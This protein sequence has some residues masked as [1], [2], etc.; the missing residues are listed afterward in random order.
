MI[1]EDKN[2][3]AKVICDS[4]AEGSI[5]RM[6]TFE[7]QFPRFILAEL[8]THGMLKKCTQSSRAVPIKALLDLYKDEFYI[9]VRFGKNQAGMSSREYLSEVE[10]MVAG[11]YWIQ[12]EASIRELVEVLS[13]KEG[14]NVHKQWA[15]R[16]YEPFMYIKLVITATEWDNFFWLRDDEDAAQP[17]MVDLARK[18]KAAR[19]ESTPN[20]LKAGEWHMPYVETI[21]ERNSRTLEVHQVFLDTDGQVIDT[22]TALMISASCCAQ[23]SYRKLDDSIEKAKVVYDKLF[24]GSKP[25]YSPTESQGRVMQGQKANLVQRVFPS[26][27]EVGVSH[28]DR[29]AQLWSG[30]LKGFVQYRKLLEQKS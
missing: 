1:F 6:T 22:D 17:E 8:N 24:G 29:T 27:L 19:D 9:P 30:N 5:N 2:I 14:L 28:M 20:V 25:H 3:W 13:D 23:S 7:I 21:W 4:I 18:M 26:L 12:A 16:L 15:A 11:G 10:D